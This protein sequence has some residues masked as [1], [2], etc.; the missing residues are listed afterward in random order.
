MWWWW[1]MVFL[2]YSHPMANILPSYHGYGRDP[3]GYLAPVCGFSSASLQSCAKTSILLIRMLGYIHI[4]QCPLYVEKLTPP[5]N[6]L[7]VRVSQ[8]PRCIWLRYIESHLSEMSDGSVGC[9][10]KSK[11]SLFITPCAHGVSPGFLASGV[12]LT[13]AFIPTW[14]KTMKEHVKMGHVSMDKSVYAQ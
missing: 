9:C 10:P 4:L 6:F 1:T 14:S 8:H 12:I 11:P 3:I 5:S 13:D 7:D 2:V